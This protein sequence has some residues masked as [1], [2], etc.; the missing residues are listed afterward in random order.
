MSLFRSATLLVLTAMLAL[1]AKPPASL[2]EVEREPD[3]EKRSSLALDFARPAVGR[4]VKAYEAGQPEEAR[5]ILVSV[6]EAATIA[7]KSLEE[8][9]KHARS[10][11]K[12]FK[13]AEIDTRKLLRDLQSAQ[14][15]L[16]FD[17]RPDLD[18]AIAKVEEINRQLLFDI[19]ER[20]K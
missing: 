16:A 14:R 20:K 11:P 9:G 18:P 5:R 1:A 3:L 12:H 4:M 15:Q 7:Q 19:M 10:K 6:V 17:E 2:E 8:T 13:R